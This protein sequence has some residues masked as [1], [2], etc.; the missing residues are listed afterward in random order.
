M[1]ANRKRQEHHV[2]AM[3]AMSLLFLELSFTALDL[4]LLLLAFYLLSFRLTG[5]R[6]APDPLEFLLI[7]SIPPVGRRGR[8]GSGFPRASLYQPRAWY[9]V[10][11][12]SPTICYEHNKS[13]R[14][15]V[16]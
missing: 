13:L 11:L 1:R 7:F 4:F 9:L 14:I 8:S 2:S 6:F 16:D 5:S 12:R 15:S 3:N 10:E